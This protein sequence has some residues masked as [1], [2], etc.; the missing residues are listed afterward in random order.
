MSHCNASEG[1]GS[2]GVVGRRRWK[3]STRWPMALFV[4]LFVLF[5]PNLLPQTDRPTDQPASQPASQ[6]V[7]NTHPSSST[8]ALSTPAH[9]RLPQS[10]T[11]NRIPQTAIHRKPPQTTTNQPTTRCN[12]LHGRLVPRL[13]KGRSR[14]FVLLPACLPAF[15]GPTPAFPPAHSPSA[16]RPRLPSGPAVTSRDS[17]PLSIRITRPI[18]P[19]AIAAVPPSDVSAIALL[20]GGRPPCRVVCLRM[21]ASRAPP[22][23]A[24]DLRWHWRWPFRSVAPS[25]S[26]STSFL[27]V[28]A[29]L[30]A[31]PCPAHLPPRQANYLYCS[32]ACQF[33]DFVVDDHQHH[34]QQQQQ[35]Q[36]Q[37]SLSHSSTHMNLDNS[38]VTPLDDSESIL[39]SLDYATSSTAGRRRSPSFN[40]HP[41]AAPSAYQ[42]L[43]PYSTSSSST[44]SASAQRTASYGS[45]AA[46]GYLSPSP[47]PDSF[48]SVLSAAGRS[49]PFA[50]ISPPSD[51]FP[52]LLRRGHRHKDHRRRSQQPPASATITG[53][54]SNQQQP[55]QHTSR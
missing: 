21:T 4:L 28:L 45:R 2:E 52:K 10:P 24:R 36:Q 40:G 22:P 55:Q 27:A 12:G 42:G 41:A 18:S 43:A 31:N 34:H 48:M 49:P 25:L 51:S 16:A 7:A 1:V 53:F 6:P 8:L 14:E 30:D 46:S 9:R 39:D 35:Q 38:W 23:A 29:V 44:A 54:P 15:H 11:A 3:A 37:L 33:A 20:P 13:R 50:P 47:S 5:G 32:Q 19:S 26:P 17:P